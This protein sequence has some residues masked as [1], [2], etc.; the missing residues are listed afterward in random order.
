[1][2]RF[3]SWMLPAME[4]SFLL[5]CLPLFPTQVYQRHGDVAC[6]VK[7]FSLQGR[8]FEGG[9]FVHLPIDI[10]ILVGTL[11]P[12]SFASAKGFHT[13]RTVLL[14]TALA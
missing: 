12:A 8:H 7:K 1:M 6:D 3:V 10:R 9:K 4:V 14:A 11:S 13:R 2:L 5:R